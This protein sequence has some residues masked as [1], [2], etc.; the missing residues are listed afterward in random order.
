MQQRRAGRGAA[1]VAGV[2]QEL[3]GSEKSCEIVLASRR[4]RRSG[5]TAAGRRVGELPRRQVAM[6]GDLEDAGRPRELHRPRLQRHGAR[7]AGRAACR[8]AAASRTSAQSLGGVDRWAHAQASIEPEMHVR[9]GRA[10]A[11]AGDRALLGMRRRCGRNQKSAR[12]RGASRRACGRGSGRPSRRRRRRR[13]TPCRPSASLTLKKQADRLPRAL[14]RRRGSGTR[15]SVPNTDAWQ[16]ALC[17]GR[18]SAAKS[19]TRAMTPAASAEGLRSATAYACL[20]P[21]AW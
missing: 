16:P 10:V 7:P 3:S 20:G 14:C 8:P 2:Q 9:A 12:S 17:Q 1:G 15:S 11:V 4:C 18:P 5:S 6:I 13:R 19:D 21:R